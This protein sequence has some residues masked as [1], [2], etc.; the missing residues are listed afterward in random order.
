[1]EKI[2][3]ADYLRLSMED[4][5]VVSNGNKMES[6][7]IAH[8]RELISRYRNDK[9]IYPEIEVLEFVDDGFSGTS[10]ERPA[11]KQ[12][13]SL[14][15]EGK[16]CCVIVKDLSRFGRNYL[17]VSDYLEQ[18]FPFMGVRFIAINDGYDSDDYI[19]TTGGIELA[20]KNLLYDMYS[21]DL[22]VKMRSALEIRRKRGDFIGPRP[23]FGY[24]F[25]KNRKV[26]EVDPVAAQYVK[27]VFELACM[28]YSTGEIAK[29]LNEEKIPTPGQYKN[30]EKLQ[31][32][33][34]PKESCW[35]SKSVRDILKN[36]VYLGMAVNGK[37]RVTKIGGKQFKKV[38]DEEQ[39]CVPDKHEAIITADDFER[40]AKTI[41]YRGNQSGKAH[42]FGNESILLGKLRCGNCKRSLVR[43]KCTKVPCFA[44]ERPKYDEDCGCFRQKVMEPEVEAFVWAQIR[45]RMQEKRQNADPQKRGESEA[46]YLAKSCSCT[47]KQLKMMERRKASLKTE[48]QYLY[49]QFK[50][51]KIDRITYLRQVEKL[52]EED[53]SL[54]EQISLL[55]DV[56]KEPKEECIESECRETENAEVFSR[57]LV[58]QY[59]NVIYVSGE[60]QFDI[61]WKV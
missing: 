22:S 29:R 9:K 5:D 40:A 46:Q 23:P 50:Q 41:Q 26:L 34:L 55:S 59:I 49:E 2:Y 8:Q 28:G 19:G 54:C 18:I 24:H 44:C 1:M 53:A 7:S 43:I 32:H 3:Q 35:N 17:E 61:V 58:E 10:F 33:M 25:S 21:K 52:R 60:K 38:A 16:I 42:H 57:E 56:S 47:D 31:Y 36:R 6:N 45:K 14:I 15:R 11:V 4:G 51:H 39:I 27:K 12:M 30:R 13:L 48:K 37:S 20:L